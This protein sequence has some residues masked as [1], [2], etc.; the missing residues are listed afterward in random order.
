MCGIAGV[1]SRAGSVSRTEQVRAMTRALTHRGPDDEGFFDDHGISMGFR[2]LAVIDL[3]YR[4]YRDDW[5]I[6]SHTVDIKYR[7][8]FAGGTFLEPRVRWYTQ[9]AADFFRYSLVD[10]E[11]LPEHAT[12]DYRQGELDA[13]TLGLRYGG[14]AFKTH[15]WSIRGEIYDQ[16]GDSSPD[17]AIGE[18]KDL[19]LFPGVRAV[20][21]AFSYSLF[22]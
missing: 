10:G 8:S 5:N 2:R 16:R 7:W 17:E 20:L 3:S 19:D 1:V 21:I 9:S 22:W 6:T 13:L 11:P 18:Q 4:Y 12:A 14:T 15:T